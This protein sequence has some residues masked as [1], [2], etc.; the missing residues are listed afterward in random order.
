IPD[1]PADAGWAQN[2]VTVAGGHGQ[3]NATNQLYWPFGLVVD[4]DQTI[5]I[6]DYANHRIIQWKMGDTNGQVVAGGNGKGNR[7]DQLNYP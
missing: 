3:G 4:D 2:G 5:V 6:A 1:I 7:L